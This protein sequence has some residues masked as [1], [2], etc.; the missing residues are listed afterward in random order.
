MEI[1]TQLLMHHPK[2]QKLTIY[3]PEISLEI[4]ERFCPVLEFTNITSLDLSHCN[5]CGKKIQILCKYLLRTKISSLR[6]SDNNIGDL[7]CKLIANILDQSKLMELYVDSNFISQKGLEFL[8][9]NYIPQ[10]FSRNQHPTFQ[11][12][13]FQLMYKTKTQTNFNTYTVKKGSI[14][15]NIRKKQKQFNY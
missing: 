12:T 10:N 4:F 8:R 9:Q 2:L 11:K 14:V 5:I 7:G 1:F 13:F 6:L 15:P 3:I